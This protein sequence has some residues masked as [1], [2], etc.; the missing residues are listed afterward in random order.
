MR[1]YTRVKAYILAGGLG[2]RLR[3]LTE[4]TPK[5]MLLLQ[6]KPLLEWLVLQFSEAGIV[7]ICMLV[8]YRSEVIKNYFGDG[9]KWGVNI[10]YRHHP[11]GFK[12]T[13]H[14]VVDAV[15]S[16]DSDNDDVIVTA[17]DILSTVDIA[18]FIDTH[19]SRGYDITAHGKTVTIPFCMIE[20]DGTHKITVVKE[21]PDVTFF[22][23]L[24]IVKRK[25]I[26]T[27]D[28]NGSFFMNIVPHMEKSGTLYRDED[29]TV[30]HVSELRNDLEEANSVWPF[31]AKNAQ[32]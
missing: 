15:L 8:H 19:T 14:A 10:T 26:Q 5:P 17:A 18:D 20:A 1:Y 21:K 30:V 11:K 28:E 6:G 29:A 13:S 12:G 25:I 4:H 3:P 32:A 24:M 9:K 16:D 2:T 22:S 7:D 31:K 23:T 27:L